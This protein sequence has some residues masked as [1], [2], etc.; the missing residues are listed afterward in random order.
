MVSSS[1]LPLLTPENL[2]KEFD[3]ISS[4]AAKAQ[5]ER[6]YT[7]IKTVFTNAALSDKMP[8]CILVKDALGREGAI[9]SANIA[10]LKAN[11]MG[12]WEVVAT[13]FG[14]PSWD[15]KVYQYVTWA[16]KEEGSEGPPAD[17]KKEFPSDR[18]A[19]VVFTRL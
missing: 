15:K 13:P 7:N 16:T 5:L 1:V 19:K 10:A 18:F 3:K 9:H 11:G 2:R 17:L 8:T 6:I 12:V 14:D 4:E